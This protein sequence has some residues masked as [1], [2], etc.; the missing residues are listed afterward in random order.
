MRRSPRTT[1]PLP[2]AAFAAGAGYGRIVILGA[3]KA[4]A[5]MAVAT[6]RH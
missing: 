4:T 2:I 1:G 5:A 3:G 6:E